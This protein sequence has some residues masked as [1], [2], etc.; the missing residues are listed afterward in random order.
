MWIALCVMST[1]SVLVFGLRGLDFAA[2]ST[3]DALHPDTPIVVVLHGKLMN[4]T[5]DSRLSCPS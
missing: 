5:I 2:P 4:Y 3:Q 1:R